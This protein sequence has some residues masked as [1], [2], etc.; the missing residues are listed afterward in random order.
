MANSLRYGLLLLALALMATSLLALELNV[1][2]TNNARTRMPGTRVEVLVGSTVLYNQTTKWCPKV[3]IAAGCPEIQDRAMAQFNLAPGTYFLRV[4]RS[5]YP[6]YIYIQTLEE[7]T[8]LTVII[9]QAKSTYT[10]YGQAGDGTGDWSGQTIKLMDE[11]DAVVKSVAIK[12]N[13]YYL[14]D[15]LWPGKKY[16]LRVD[17]GGQRLLSAPF[18]R[19]PVRRRRARL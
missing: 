17:R 10:V 6:D 13:G 7:D 8:D 12:G 14:I 5:A 11:N 19:C 16:Y 18:S 3:D 4:R 9:M 15:S 2:V 1:S